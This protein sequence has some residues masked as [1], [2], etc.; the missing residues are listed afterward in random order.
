MKKNLMISALIILIMI[1]N[2][3]EKPQKKDDSFLKE[4]PAEINLSPEQIALKHNEALSYVLKELS[5]KDNFSDVNQMLF[6]ARKTLINYYEN[7]SDILYPS[8]EYSYYSTILENSFDKV[9]DKELSHFWFP[10]NEN[11]LTNYQMNILNDDNLSLSDKLSEF[12]II[13]EECNNSQTATRV[14]KEVLII[15]IEVGMKS[16]EYWHNHQDEWVALVDNG[17]KWFDWGEVAGWDLAGAIG[18]AAGAAATGAG[19]GAG[20]VGGAIGTSVA[21]GVYQVWDHYM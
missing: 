10:E 16:M 14:E 21:N 5:T 9:D 18:G 7:Q 6:E 13:K 15:A 8:D 11:Q 4:D 1:M 17:S 19:I 2:S 3:C 20:A 12:S